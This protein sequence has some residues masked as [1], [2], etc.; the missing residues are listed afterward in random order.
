M[1]ELVS[2]YTANGYTDAV[3]KALQAEDRLSDLVAL[4]DSTQAAPRASGNSL[5]VDSRGILQP[6]DW[7]NTSPPYLLSNPL[8]FQEETLLGLVFSQLDTSQRALF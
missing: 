8:P 3:A 4:R 2:I 7:H 5:I 6:I 1:T